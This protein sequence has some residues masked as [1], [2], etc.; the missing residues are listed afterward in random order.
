MKEP[1]WR[2]ALFNLKKKEEISTTVERMMRDELRKQGGDLSMKS[3]I[4]PKR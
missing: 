2:P 3:S 1:S 4:S